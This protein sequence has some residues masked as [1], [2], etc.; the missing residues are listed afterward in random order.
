M[1]SRG[2]RGWGVGHG[3][4][5]IVLRVEVGHKIGCSTDSVGPGYNTRSKTTVFR[6]LKPPPPHHWKM[7]A[8]LCTAF[9]ESNNIRIRYRLLNVSSSTLFSV[10]TETII[11]PSSHAV[12][13]WLSTCGS[14]NLIVGTLAP[15]PPQNNNIH[16]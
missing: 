13:P 2:R 15:P 9:R 1:C 8:P 5:K 10:N 12:H 3:G 4:P 6:C 7:T 16:I 14:P 11:Q